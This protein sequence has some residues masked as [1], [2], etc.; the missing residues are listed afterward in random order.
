GNITTE[1]SDETTTVFSDA[2]RYELGTTLPKLFGGFGTS[3]NAYGIDFS[4]QCSFQL[5][6]KYYDGNYQQLMWT[7]ASA[8]QAWHKDVLNAWTPTNTNTNIPRMDGDTQ[9]AQSAV[10][11]FFISSNYLSI[12]NITLGYTLPKA[13]TKKI[14]IES[15]RLY[16]AGENLAVFA[17]RKG[18]DPRNTFGLG[19]FTM[20]AGSSSYGAMRSITGGVTLTF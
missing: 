9:V 16:V 2:T 5:G 12:N 14:K 1:A 13:W 19:S 4:I 7:Q 10:D 6:G 15:L 3:L 11:R 17:A 20:D 8:G 18:V